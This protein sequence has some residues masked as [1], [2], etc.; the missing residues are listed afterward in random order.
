MKRVW[1]ILVVLALLGA[2]CG[3]DG[4]GISIGSGGENDSVSS[5]DGNDEAA[6]TDSED[7]ETS[8]S[9]DTGD[10]GGD[11]CVRALELD[12]RLEVL[13]D[14]DI[15]T[16]DLLRESFENA[17]SLFDDLLDNPPAEIR[18]DVE[19]SVEGFRLLV[20][21]LEDADFNFLN[22][23]LRA[24]DTLDDPKYDEAGD[25][26]QQYLEDECGL[27]PDDDDDSID[28]FADPT[29]GDDSDDGDDLLD[30]D[31]PEGGTIRDVMIDSLESSGF[32][33]DEAGC[34]ADQLGDDLSAFSN[35]DDPSAILGLFD[36]CNIDLA[37]LAELGG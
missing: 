31:L 5:D 15:P 2:A 29:D 30:T 19:T 34:L 26:I 12:D 21:A 28:D 13:D 24:F 7:D 25:N 4:E 17:D 1:M 32:S 22:V 8:S 16:A 18:G 37:R 14:A 10:G 35:P 11:W 27:E 3:G 20:D 6:G 33:A 23:D 9:A 36:Q